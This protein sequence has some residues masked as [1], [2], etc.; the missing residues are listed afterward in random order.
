M[1]YGD[2][3]RPRTTEVS[4]QFFEENR[5]KRAPHPPGSPDLALSN[6]YQ[7]GYVKGY[8]IGFEFQAVK[9]LPE[10]VQAGLDGFEQ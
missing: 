2:N 7:F 5:M 1:V 6:F 4:T 8:L 10:V 3:A 9:Q